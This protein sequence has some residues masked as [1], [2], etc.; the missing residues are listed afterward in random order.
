MCTLKTADEAGV[1]VKYNPS[2]LTINRK[3]IGQNILVV[4]T[5]EKKTNAGTVKSRCS[6]YVTVKGMYI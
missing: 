4:A 5:A 2:T 3:M 1:T 6:F